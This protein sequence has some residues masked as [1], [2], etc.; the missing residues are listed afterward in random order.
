MTRLTQRSVNAATPQE[1][2]VFL[3]DSDLK[4]FGL[5]VT[6]AGSKIYVST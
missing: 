2:D 1:R 4:G 5:K 6:P 3:W